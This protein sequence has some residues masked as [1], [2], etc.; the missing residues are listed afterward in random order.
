[1]AKY[2]QHTDLVLLR[3]LERPA[4]DTQFILAAAFRVGPWTVPGGF[5]TDLAS[6]PRLLRSIVSKVDGIEAS[7]IHDWLYHS[8]EV[9]RKEADRIFLDLLDGVVPEWRRRAMYWAVRAF[10]K[11]AYD[12]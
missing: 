7:I 11:G 6:V 10:G 3:Q 9:T 4:S 12:T 5:E 1:M 8:R 2:I